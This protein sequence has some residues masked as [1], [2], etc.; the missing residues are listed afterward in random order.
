MKFVYKV[1]ASVFGVG[2]SPV[3][4]G[5]VGSA[6]TIVVIYF[7]GP[8]ATMG[9]PY[10]IGAVLLLPIGAFISGKGEM[11]WG[12]DSGK[13]VFDEL[14]G[15]YY[16]LILI[17]RSIPFFVLGFVVFRVLDI[18]KPPPASVADKK[19]KGGWGVLL[20]DVACGIYANILLQVVRLFWK[21]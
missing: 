15:M 10:L 6:V 3:A 17:P 19:I 13:I 20:D 11:L 8:R 16:T 18:V 2:Y 9:L 5:T 1:L 7:L 4:S 12:H 14:V 21:G